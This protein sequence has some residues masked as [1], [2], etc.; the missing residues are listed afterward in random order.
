MKLIAPVPASLFALSSWPAVPKWTWIPLS[1]VAPC[2]VAPW[3]S[4]YGATMWTTETLVAS[5]ISCSSISSPAALSNANLKFLA[6]WFEAYTSCPHSQTAAN[7]LYPASP[8]AWTLT[9]SV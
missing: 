3:I 8:V 5:L 1:L 6:P 7:L 2:S 4:Q 9:Y